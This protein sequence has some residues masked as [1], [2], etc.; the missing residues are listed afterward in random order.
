MEDTF[1]ITEEVQTMITVKITAGGKS[2]VQGAGKWSYAWINNA[3]ET[4]I[5][6]TTEWGTQTVTER[7]AEYE[8]GGAKDIVKLPAGSSKRLRANNRP[9]IIFG[10]EA[11][12]A[13][14]D[15]TNTDV[16][17][18]KVQ[19]KGGDD[20][21][22]ES[23]SVTE[24]GTYTASG[25]VKGY[26]PVSVSVQPNVGTKNISDNGTYTASAD[27]LDGYSSVT[28]AVSKDFYP[29][30]HAT[31]DDA[32]RVEGDDMRV[33]PMGGTDYYPYV[34]LG[35]MPYPAQQGDDFE[36]CGKYFAGQTQEHTVTTFLDL[37]D[38]ATGESVSGY[39]QRVA[40]NWSVSIVDGGY[41]RIVSWTV[42]AS[43]AVSVTT[44]RYN[45][46]YTKPL[47]DTKDSAAVTGGKLDG[48]VDASY[49]IDGGAGES[50]LLQSLTATANG[51]Y[52]APART[53]YNEVTVDVQEQLAKG[54]IERS[55]TNVVIPDTITIIG[56]YA[57]YGCQELESVTIPNSVTQIKS[58]AFSNCLA[59]TDITIPNTVTS[60]DSYAFS[61]C[62]F[63]DI[64]IPSSV[65]YIN[66][67]LFNYC[68]H[69]KRAVINA[70]V[71]SLGSNCFLGCEALTDVTLPSS[72]TNIGLNMFQNC[73]SLE[74]ITIPNSVTSISGQAFNGCTSLTD[75]TL[76]SSLTSIG[77]Q[78]FNRC[79]ALEAITIPNTVTS[80]GSYAFQ[81]CTSLTD[82]TLSSSLTSIGSQAFNRCTALEAITIPNT[83]TS[84]GSRAFSGCTSLQTITINKAEGSITGAP[85][86][87]T[88]ATVVW[89]G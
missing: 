22:I 65:T 89:T 60:I 21:K 56:E 84:I 12:M 25:E 59:L 68:I 67:Y 70:I 33:Y 63:T 86:G 13:E 29:K 79:T 76:S 45:P 50:V 72:L 44:E 64:I 37:I 87:A 23:L 73:T 38:V 53:A 9:V 4:A 88:N 48:Y 24:N 5:Y 49:Y 66:N 16:S 3:G 78:A 61:G 1:F 32:S 55:I 41:M 77:S 47:Q 39:P 19:A 42:K 80:I 75:V 2:T 17:P 27:Q 35:A 34:Y 36:P 26:S 7:I 10:A 82:V 54:I 31:L 18:F 62:A 74:S 20:G 51:T 15:L 6:A 30:A 83:V 40:P 58:R 43:G 46:T 69:L 81:D 57:F 71:T 52:T 85:W 28:V 14:V 8:A 11:G